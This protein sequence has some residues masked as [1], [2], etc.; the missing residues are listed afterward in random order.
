MAM[1]FLMTRLRSM[2][3]KAQSARIMR[4]NRNR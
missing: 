3:Q 4:M 2:Q 1:P